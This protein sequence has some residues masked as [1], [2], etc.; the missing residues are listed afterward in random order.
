MK[1]V[2]THSITLAFLSITCST[3]GQVPFECPYSGS[4][5][6]LVRSV[7][8]NVKRY[9]H[10][11]QI[12]SFMQ[13][14]LFKINNFNV[15]LPLNYDSI[16]AACIHHLEDNLGSELMCQ[17]IELSLMSL[18]V[19]SHKDS[20]FLSF[21]FKYPHFENQ[22]THFRY[23]YFLDDDGKI[24]IDYPK[25]L[26]EYRELSE[27]DYVMTRDRVIQKLDYW[28]LIKENDKVH[29][30]LSGM[31]WKV[32]LSTDGSDFRNLSVHLITGQFSNF[33]SELRTD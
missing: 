26:S 29:V 5:D 27:A 2:I 14:E 6:S 33:R 3:F 18:G 24:I 7:I 12:E 23:E 15:D 30:E 11:E 1:R 31:N 28:G 13:D 22:W 16:F 21:R 20:Y 8:Q 17:N 32:T 25:G 10:D 9:Y 4:S 19:L